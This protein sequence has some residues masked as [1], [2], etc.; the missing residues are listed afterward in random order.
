MPVM[1][2]RVKKVVFYSTRQ[3]HP[4]FSDREHL[5][6][7]DS[8]IWYFSKLDDEFSHWLSDLA[9]LTEFLH[10]LEE[11]GKKFEQKDN[12][13]IKK[14]LEEI[15]SIVYQSELMDIHKTR[16]N[17]LAIFLNKQKKSD[18]VNLFWNEA[19][20]EYI[21][22]NNASIL[23]E[24]KHYDDDKIR[25]Q[26]LSGKV[27]HLNRDLT[28]IIINGGSSEVIDNSSRVKH[29]LGIYHKE[30]GE[31]A[32]AAVWPWPKGDTLEPNHDDNWKKVIVDAIKELYPNIDE[33]ILV[34]HDW[35]L[36]EW[37]EKDQ[38]VFRK[39]PLS[40]INESDYYEDGLS[41]NDDLCISL[42]VFQHTNGKVL[43]PLYK[44]RGDHLNTPKQ[45]WEAID[46]YIESVCLL[47][48]LDKEDLITKM[49]S[50]AID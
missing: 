10:R 50:E 19:F 37:K 3:I 32:V 38:I 6:R 22:L 5:F 11:N 33:I 2:N 47:M 1:N 12:N 29:R 13:D 27:T 49:H 40:R 17:D 41:S 7:C 44:D 21:N 34:I 26:I 48:K 46:K 18:I 39:R 20:Q 24:P 14:K 15:R 36:E 42:I 31:Y 28:E 45:V 23:F 43:E 4:Y 9:F 25:N 30:E 8:M 16:V 35:D